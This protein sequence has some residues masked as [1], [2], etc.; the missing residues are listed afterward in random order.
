MNHNDLKKLNIL[1]TK[2]MNREPL[3]DEEF[4]EF[5]KL[6]IERVQEFIRE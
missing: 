3:S 5:K 6:L 4:R 1:E 2:N